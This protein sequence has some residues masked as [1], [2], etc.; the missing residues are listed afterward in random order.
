MEDVENLMSLSYEQGQ[1]LVRL[2]KDLGQKLFSR[3]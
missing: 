2:I 1:E 3:F